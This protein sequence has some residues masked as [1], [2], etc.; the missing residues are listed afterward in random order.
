MGNH[1]NAEDAT[2]M[3]FTALAASAGDLGAY[4]SLGGWL[5]STAWHIARP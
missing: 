5:Y 1:A 3:T 2:Q 4:R